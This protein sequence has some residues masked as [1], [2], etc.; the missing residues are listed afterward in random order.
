MAINIV[1]ELKGTIIAPA[2]LIG[3][4]EQTN[5]L[6][7]IIDVSYDKA[8]IGQLK[9][10]ITDTT[11]LVGRIAGINNL[12]GIVSLSE[13]VEPYQGD[14]IITP[15]IRSQYMNTKNKKMEKNIRVLAIPYYETSNLTGKTVYIG[16]E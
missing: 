5:T 2:C 3:Q 15:Q 16:G 1:G 14:Y 10:V 4:I 6:K 7:G 12:K 9:A 13:P 8:Y 11:N